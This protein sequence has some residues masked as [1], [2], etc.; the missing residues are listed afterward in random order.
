LLL[1]TWQPGES[2]SELAQRVLDQDLLGR[3]TARRVLDIVHV[4]AL[5]YL[6]PDD[7][8]AR[9]LKTIT[10]RDAERQV[11]SDLVLYYIARRDAL[12][13]DFLVTRFWPS[14]REGRLVISNNEMQ[15]LIRDAEQDG[16]IP[17]PG[18]AE[19]KRD[20]AGRVMITLTD[21]GLVRALKPATREVVP[22]RLSDSATV[23]FAYLLHEEG[24]TDASLADHEAWKVFG[25]LPEEVWGRLDR[26]AS[27]GWFEVQRAG[28][29]VRITWAYGSVEEAIDA[30]AR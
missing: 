3:A 11:L 7:R 9:H 16:R 15:Q 19:I 27:E 13:H 24:V 21:L 5:R 25:L 2:E 29:V 23:Y 20:M 10:E 8:P 14:V 22:Y 6:T 4:F 26:L 17:A 30:V 28:Q 1:Q 18:S 12:L